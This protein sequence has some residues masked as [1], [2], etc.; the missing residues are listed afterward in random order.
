MNPDVFSELYSIEE[1]F[2]YEFQET[3]TFVLRIQDGICTKWLKSY[4]NIF[5]TKI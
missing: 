4:Y 5:W 1:I 3:R 2:M